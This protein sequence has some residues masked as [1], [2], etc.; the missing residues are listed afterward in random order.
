[1]CSVEIK[2]KYVQIGLKDLRTPFGLM[3]SSLLLS[4]VGQ[5][6]QTCCGCGGWAG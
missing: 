4:S 1:M 6:S 2:K 3:V 5:Q